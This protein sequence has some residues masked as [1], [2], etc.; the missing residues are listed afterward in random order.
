[1]K[2]KY[3]KSCTLPHLT[4]LVAG[5]Q[6]NSSLQ[7]ESKWCRRTGVFTVTVVNDS[8]WLSVSEELS[9]RHEWTNQS[10]QLPKNQ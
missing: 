7:Q 2:V 9:Q 3:F 8:K 1:M 4:S 5:N 6:P 10:I